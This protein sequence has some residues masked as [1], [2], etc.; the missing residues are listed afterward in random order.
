MEHLLLSFLLWLNKVEGI[1][2]VPTEVPSTWES[3]NA[4]SESAPG[5]WSLRAESS[6]LVEE[7]QKSPD[8][9]IQ[10]PA[11]LYGAQEIY[12]NGILLLKFGDPT[13]KTP[14]YVVSSPVLACRSL[15]EAG[16]LSWQVTA[17][18]KYY[19][20]LPY[21]PTLERARPLAKLFG[22]TLCI[23][24]AI[25][26]TVLSIFSLSILHKKE[27]KKL[28]TAMSAAM[29]ALAG[30]QFSLVAPAFNLSWSMLNVNRLGDLC[31]VWGIFATLLCYRIEGFIPKRLFE[32][33]LIFSLVSLPVHL[34]ATNGD[35]VQF[36]TT[37]PMLTVILNFGIATYQMFKK[38]WH[39]RQMDSGLMCVFNAIFGA[40]VIN[41][42][43]VFT[44][45]SS[46]YVYMSIG[47][48]LSFLI[49]ILA[50][51]QRIDATY[52]ERDYLRSNLEIEVE[53]KT[54]ELKHTQ[55]ELIQ[56]AKLA[57]LGTLSA[58]IAHEINNSINFVNGAIP[59][60]E[61]LI[62]KLEPVSE[63]D[64]TVGKK[65]LAAIKDGIS[66]TVDIVKS[67]R[68]FTGL[69]QAKLKDVSI[70]EV[71]KSVTT[72][73]HSKLKDD[74]KVH[75]DVPENLLLYGDVVGINQVLMNLFTNAIDAMPSGGE[76]S[77]RAY[78][79][80]ES[81]VIEVRD[82]GAGIP[83]DVKTKIFDP[84]FTTKEVGSGTGLGLYIVTKEMEK[85]G[86]KVQVH[87][88]SGRG[89]TFQLSFPKKVHQEQAEAA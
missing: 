6:A 76:I 81:T 84:F 1:N 78:D 75:V 61:K 41:D 24:S 34:F 89:T 77:V 57:S 5:V 38:F 67:L 2:D 40:V 9:F 30:Y 50:V 74:Y 56:S 20:R 63:R 80:G 85:H 88:Q 27:S 37:L 15:H 11:V 39:D 68:Q 13:M 62:N 83:D 79:Q 53:R 4:W 42:I 10:F 86:G 26:L 12:Q 71:T 36:G 21:Y 51:N 35:V 3:A 18:S 19:A 29:I 87:S 14:N 32:A 58:G 70:R 66:I 59:P 73:L 72:I 55:A 31:L 46:G 33:H 25:G 47:V 17:Y 22:E 23:G 7:C 52:R 82:T 48:L 64:Y 8:S 44:G 65:L 16:A 69:N 43:N 45:S 49:L 28:T 54:A 60:L